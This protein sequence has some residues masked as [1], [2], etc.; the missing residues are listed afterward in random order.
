MVAMLQRLASGA[1]VLDF[2]GHLEFRLNM[3][4]LYFPLL[5]PCHLFNEL[6][7]ISAAETS[8][9]TMVLKLALQRL[10]LRNI[11]D[12]ESLLTITVEYESV[13]PRQRIVL[14]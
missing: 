3:T 4:D 6:L 8:L 10:C 7:L 13:V 5:N 9:W 11:M 14:A 12:N 1:R 2:G